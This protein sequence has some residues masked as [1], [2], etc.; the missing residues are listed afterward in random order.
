MIEF[1]RPSS[2]MGQGTITA[3]DVVTFTE[4]PSGQG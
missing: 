1:A 4:I 3:S 2:I